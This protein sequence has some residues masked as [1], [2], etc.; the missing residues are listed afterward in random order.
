[1]KCSHMRFAVACAGFASVFSVSTVF[2]TTYYQGEDYGYVHTPSIW[3]TSEGTVCTQVTSTDELISSRHRLKLGSLSEL[4]FAGKSLVIGDAEETSVVFAQFSMP[5]TYAIRTYSFGENPAGL[6]LRNGAFLAAQGDDDYHIRIY[7]NILV[8]QSAGVNAFGLCLA[9]NHGILVR[10]AG[11]LSSTASSTLEIGKSYP[12]SATLGGYSMTYIT[13]RGVSAS[14]SV[15]EISSDCSGFLGRMVITNQV[16]TASLDAVGAL[17]QWG[18]MVSFMSME[19]G[20]EMAVCSGN[21]L[22]ATDYDQTLAM[23]S[24]VL[25]DGAVLRLPDVPASA[26]DNKRLVTEVLAGNRPVFSAET[27]SIRGKAIIALNGLEPMANGETNI[28]EIVSVPASCELDADD[29]ELA[30]SEGLCVPHSLEVRSLH[31][32]RK[33]LC[34]VCEPY[35]RLLRSDSNNVASGMQAFDLA[36]TNAAA[37]SDGKLPRPNVNSVV[38]PLPGTELYI[39]TPYDDPDS[40]CRFPGRQLIV[41]TNCYFLSHCSEFEFADKPLKMLGGSAIMFVSSMST[42]FRGG[43]EIGHGK[44]GMCPYF[45]STIEIDRLLGDGEFAIADTAFT[46][47][48]MGRHYFRDTSAFKG[49]ITVMQPRYGTDA[50]GEGSVN[51]QTGLPD[52]RQFVYVCNNAMGGRLDDFDFKSLRLGR[53]ASLYPFSS[54]E[55]LRDDLNRGMMI[56]GIAYLRANDDSRLRIDWPITFN[57][58]LIKAGPGTVSLGGNRALFGES[59]VD[60]PVPGGIQGIVVSEGCLE[61][62]SANAVNGVTISVTNGATV[63]LVC[64]PSNPDLSQYGLKN[65]KTSVPFVLDPVSN[66]KLPLEIDASAFA[67]GGTPESF[68]FG[69][70]TVTNDMAVS[71][72]V[73]EMLPEITYLRVAGR[74]YAARLTETV[75]GDSQTR[76]FRV[77]AFVRG[78]TIRIR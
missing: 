19:F 49:R 1:M 16:G 56:D 77:Q 8:D 10:L 12:S 60:M 54:S 53:W 4:S 72:T 59:A 23:E 70:V 28:H 5:K 63:R 75:D 22:A 47:A 41:G 21:V 14:N 6:V 78:C 33:T 3:R 18:T 20:G 31:S 67:A 11:S 69:L 50:G 37:W 51:P 71:A 9:A 39:R 36:L 25:D 58:R 40:V 43:V 15:V 66:G 48:C 7:G 68:A 32:G 74:R 13:H 42:K 27:L 45:A 76:T 44:V 57:G 29:F 73:R 46:W 55:W 17:R 24:L 34:L 62:C 61:I 52:Y 26:R 64:D 2:A 65:V 38:L 35:Q 30:G